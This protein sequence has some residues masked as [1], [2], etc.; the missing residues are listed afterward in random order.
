MNTAC[1]MLLCAAAMT[2]LSACAT[3]DTASF[4]PQRT[5]YEDSAYVAAV[6]DAAA[7]SPVR[8]RVLWVNPPDRRSD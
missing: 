2:L 5:I 6:E 4:K 1:K 8:V 7:H 3:A